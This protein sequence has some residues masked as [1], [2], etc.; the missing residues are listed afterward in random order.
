MYYEGSLKRFLAIFLILIALLGTVA[1]VRP[2]PAFEA[3]SNLPKLPDTGR[4]SIPWP[5]YG[6]A[7]FGAMGFGVLATNG[8]QK[9]VPIASIAKVIT[10]LAVIQ[11][12]PLA[13]GE[14][15]PN[16]TMTVADVT[17]YKKY[18]AQG[19]SVVPVKA[20]E[21]ISEYQ[22]LQA[23]LIPSAN[24]I[25]DGLANWA[26]GS[27]VNYLK[28]ANDL[29]QGLSLQQTH[30]ADASG[31]S[32]KSVSSAHDLVILGQ[33]LLASP[34]LAQIVGQSYAVTTVASMVSNTNW[35]LGT[36]GVAGIKT[37]NTDQAGGCFLF[38]ANRTIGGQPIKVVG[39]IL[40]APD[41]NKAITDSLPII[42]ASENNFGLMQVVKKGQVAGKYTAKWGASSQVV[43]VEDL[44]MI[45]WKGDK[46]AVALNLDEISGSVEA[47]KKVG[48][49]SVLSGQNKRSASVTLQQ[50]IPAP[51]PFWRIFHF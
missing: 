8:T 14:Q 46:P 4:A 1:Y 44:S 50:Q 39:A 9:A 28:Y 48:L 40:G 49:L 30:V 31:F 36:E 51:S 29:L 17:I 2:L 19:G 35:L 22:A 18:V 25:A 42:R 38:T 10:A 16:I 21:K 12:K 34:V 23:M 32:P 3:Q 26:F 47:G 41:R 37:G 24:N 6:Q 7:A 13:I 15:G 20:G 5:A 45:I 27:E 33:K 43:A 11:Q